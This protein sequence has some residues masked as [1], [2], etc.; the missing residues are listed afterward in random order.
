MELTAAHGLRQPNHAPEVSSPTVAREPTAPGARVAR[1]GWISS[2]TRTAGTSTRS[3]RQ[4]MS[5][6]DCQPASPYCP[7]DWRWRR[8]EG[9]LQGLL[10][11]PGR[12]ADRWV[13]RALRFQHSHAEM[14]DSS[15]PKRAR[16]DPAVLG[17]LQLNSSIEPGPRL[18]LEAR[19]L[20]RQTTGEIAARLGFSIEIVEAYQN[21]FFDV[22]DRLGESSYIMAVVI[23]HSLH[24][25]FAAGDMDA[26]LKV[27]A[28]GYGPIVLDAVI[29]ELEVGGG[30]LPAV[31]V[32][33]KL[34]Q[35]IRMAITARSIPVNQQTAPGLIRLNARFLEIEREAAEDVALNAP[36][37]ATVEPFPEARL[38]GQT[39]PMTPTTHTF[40]V[41]MR[42]GVNTTGDRSGD[43]TGITVV[44]PELNLIYTETS[45]RRTA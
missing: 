17:A 4:N 32:N 5:L 11:T 40:G 39:S 43:R 15:C 21:L 28:Y 34:A 29:E 22:R 37:R 13:R 42:I 10:P 12:R 23:K 24:D 27:Y 31:A 20:A 7:V 41:G 16:K 9:I 33:S 26:I 3:R 30:T 1:E 6:L 36:V 18:Q 25:G 44:L 2:S 45:T 14:G 8:A 19:V 38:G 35:S